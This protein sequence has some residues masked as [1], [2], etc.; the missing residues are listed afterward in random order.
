MS[1]H[2][3]GTNTGATE[4]GSFSKAWREP[5][6][7][8]QASG[9]GALLKYASMLF[10][11]TPETCSLCVPKGILLQGHLPLPSLALPQS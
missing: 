1:L 11:C 2:K 6:R 8:P 10:C 4:W 9:S 7:K 3:V 5:G